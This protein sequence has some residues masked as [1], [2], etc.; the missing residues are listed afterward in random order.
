VL[1][2]RRAHTAEPADLL[3]PLEAE[4][5]AALWRHPRLGVLDATAMVNANRGRRLSERTVATILRRLD[6]KGY[7]SHV[8]EGRAYLYT[9]VVAE[10]DF[11]A[12]HGRRAMGE[13]LRRYGP[14]VALSGLVEQAGAEGSALEVLEDLLRR[15]R[16]E[17]ATGRLG[18]V[19][20]EADAT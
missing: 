15:Y 18:D 12:W 1:V 4:V 13:L 9:A 11:V 7:A 3:S 10:E 6:A 2:K 19:E 20:R 14:E 17:G 16:I 8:V 5:M